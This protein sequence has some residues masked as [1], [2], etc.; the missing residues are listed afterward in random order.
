MSALTAPPRQKSLLIAYVMWACL[1]LLGA[2][3]YYMG[4]KWTATLQ[5][6]LTVFAVV[7]RHRV[8]LCLV[9]LWSFA[10]AIWLYY[11]VVDSQRVF[12]ASGHRSGLAAGQATDYELER[13]GE[14]QA[15]YLACGRRGDLD[16][17]ID[18]GGKALTL[19]T[20]SFGPEDRQVN[21]IISHLGDYHRRR[22]EYDLA[23][24]LLRTSIAT[25][26]RGL[27][28]ASPLERERLLDALN[29]LGLAYIATGQRKDAEASFQ[30]AIAL[31]NSPQ[32]KKTTLLVSHHEVN[33]ATVLQHQAQLYRDGGGL[34]KAAQLIEVAVA[35]IPRFYTTLSGL[36][37]DIYSTYASILL[38]EGHLVHAAEQYQRA[39]EILSQG[40][41]S[42]PVERV[43]AQATC[44]AGLGH[45]YSQQ[46]RLD[47]AEHELITALSLRKGM[48][49]P[50]RV[51]ILAVLRL[52]GAV[53]VKQHDWPRAETIAKQVVHQ[54]EQMLGKDD[55][56]TL[57]ARQVLARISDKV[58][59]LHGEE[60]G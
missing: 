22:G 14:L 51:D 54:R 27:A 48:E 53:Y 58:L 57:Q 2:H 47:D 11:A 45:I 17:A 5:V 24:T 10:D 44:R 36:T 32:F 42:T 39:L 60:H 52:L 38:R 26:E 50:S 55:P 20:K 25:Q 4:R 6:A 9:L 40:Q 35:L 8:G 3:R 31:L 29:S 7:L 59:A 43:M 28:Q 12:A 33:L 56:Q 30:R 41:E 19:A 1:G 16:S 37:V 18:I 21:L 49:Y 23:I 34:R 46:G 13:L 15:L